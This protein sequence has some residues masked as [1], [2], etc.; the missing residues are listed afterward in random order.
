MKGEGKPEGL[1]DRIF[2]SLRDLQGER[3]GATLK[4]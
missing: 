1:P 2:S 3:R 4:V